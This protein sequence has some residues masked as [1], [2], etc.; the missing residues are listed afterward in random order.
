LKLHPDW[1]K[2][3]I[4]GYL[5]QIAICI[6]QERFVTP[7][8]K[9]PCPIVLPVVIRGI[10]DVKMAHELLEVPQRGFD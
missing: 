1:I 10:G 9:M 6:H 7:L 2:V 4:P 5:L 3:N 8:V